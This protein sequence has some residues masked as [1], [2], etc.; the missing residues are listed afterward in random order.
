MVS[1]SSSVR[2]HVKLPQQIFPRDTV[3]SWDKKQTRKKFYF[4]FFFFFFFLLLFLLLHSKHISG[5]H[6]FWWVFGYMTIFIPA[7]EVFTFRLHGWCMLGMFLLQAF[8]RLGY[9]CQDI[10]TLCDEMHVCT[11]QTSVYTLIRKSFGG[12][13]SELMLTPRGKNPF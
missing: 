5:F 13:E 10:L 6:H 1:T 7:I 9:E 8:T 4:S 2:Y 11:D 12:I 3:S